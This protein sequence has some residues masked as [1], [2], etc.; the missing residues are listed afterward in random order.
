M[1]TSLIPSKPLGAAER[2]DGSNALR[3]P[4]V[5]EW[6]WVEFAGTAYPTNNPDYVA[7][8]F[9][10]LTEQ[11][12]ER[13][14]TGSVR[15]VTHHEENGERWV[16]CELLCA[17]VSLGSNYVELQPISGEKGVTSGSMRIHLDELDELAVL[18]L[19][20]R[21]FIGAQ[22]SRMRQ[23]VALLLEEVDEV[24]RRL[25]VGQL[26]LDDHSGAATGA[27][28]TA[29]GNKPAKAFVAELTTAK[30]ETLP[31]LFER[32]EHANYQMAQWMKAELLPLQ[33][34][35]KQL[36]PLLKAVDARIFNVEL[37][38]GLVEETKLVRKGKPPTDPTTPI[39]LFQRRLYMDE[40]T[41]WGYE[42]GGMDFQQVEDFDRWLSLPANFERILPF[43]RCVVAFS[44]RRFDKDYKWKGGHWRDFISFC[45][46]LAESREL[47]RMTFLYLRNGEQL[48]RLTIKDFTFGDEGELFPDQ[49]LQQ[50]VGPLYIRPGGKHGWEFITAGDF[51]DQ[52]AKYEE[53][54][55][56]FAVEMP[57]FRREYAAWR[58]KHGMLLSVS[59]S[60]HDYYSYSDWVARQLG[61]AAL[62]WT[63]DFALNVSQGKYEE[64]S[65]DGYPLR[66]AD[67]RSM[68]VERYLKKGSRE[69][70]AEFVQ[71]CEEAKRARPIRPSEPKDP[72]YG[73]MPFDD[74]NVYADDA[75]AALAAQRD[76]HN[77]LV[78]ILQGLLDRSEAFS[79][80][81]RWRLWESR[82]FEA[83]LVLHYD[84]SRA[85]VP[86]E[87]APKF[88]ALQAEL[89]QR[90]KVGSVIVG[91]QY[92][93]DEQ[94]DELRDRQRERRGYASIDT[95]VYGHGPGFVSRVVRVSRDKKTVTVEWSV[96]KYNYR[97]N[98]ESVK[99]RT[100][101]VPVE[102]VLCLDHY[103]PGTMKQFF[104][105]TRTRTE[106]AEWAPFLMAG[107]DFAA[108]VL[109]PGQTEREL[110]SMAEPKVQR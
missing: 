56:S 74:T 85:L 87:E 80:H 105:D 93:F 49:Q 51:A 99:K 83:A 95:S 24:T 8:S 15:N 60:S 11:L 20:P 64:A 73:F 102:K 45:E 39:H 3:L 58:K 13:F 55:K 101:A 46:G 89:N 66:D 50:L 54:Q 110:R 98:V 42:A 107:E 2:I 21:E 44:V 31:Q 70:H 108:G 14:V 57:L 96:T 7:R 29:A 61:M 68:L 40:E 77:R 79:P 19:N 72:V 41:L 62:G 88:K 81:P 106:Y 36:K 43:E 33:A 9:D 25:G 52:K 26:S 103:I 17:V 67:T 4:R 53:A 16:T 23:C 27:L 104:N 78:L 91:A 34:Q 37:Y 100:L 1:P 92:V 71:L 59:F 6:Y 30:K 18:E 47:N 38:A 48:S 109:E 94:M 63:P 28:V 65:V 86:S 5:G 82:D 10:E 12:V 32:I 90:I 69:L 22:V 97:R 76:Y 75:R 84:N 35:A